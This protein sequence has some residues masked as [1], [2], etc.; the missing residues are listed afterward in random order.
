MF[1]A[2][3]VW[4]I[5]MTKHIYYRAGTIGGH[6]PPNFLR[7]SDVFHEI[8]PPNPLKSDHFLIS[9]PLLPKFLFRPLNFREVVPGHI[10][11]DQI[12][13]DCLK[14]IATIL[15]KIGVFFSNYILRKNHEIWDWLFSTFQFQLFIVL[16]ILFLTTETV[17]LATENLNR[18]H[19]KKY[20]FLGTYLLR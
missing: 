16:C 15:M 14:M 5:R 11:S 3:K 1:T 4:L 17:P 10:L 9:I 18:E 6:R 8:L 2:A 13:Q 19:P 20:W 7:I 12:F